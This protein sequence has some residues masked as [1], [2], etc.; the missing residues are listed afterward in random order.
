MKTTTEYEASDIKDDDPLHSSLK[1]AIL[2]AMI[3]TSGAKKEADKSGQ[4]AQT[5]ATSALNEAVAAFLNTLD[6]AGYV[7][8]A[9]ETV[10]LAFRG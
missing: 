7:I 5:A 4:D 8:S 9:K 10:P 1:L 3:I 2:L 6:K